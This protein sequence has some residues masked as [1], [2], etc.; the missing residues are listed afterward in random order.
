MSAA[1]TPIV[2]RRRVLETAIRRTPMPPAVGPQSTHDRPQVTA[3]AAYR[4]ALATLDSVAQLSLHDF[5]A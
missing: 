1:R 4:A 2:D 5:L 3:A